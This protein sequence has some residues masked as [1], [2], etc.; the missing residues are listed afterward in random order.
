MENFIAWPIWIAIYLFLGG[1][2]AGA[3]LVAALSDLFG[4]EKYRSMARTAAWLVPGP[5]VLGLVLLIY[6]LGLPFAF[7]KLMIYPN[8]GSVM[9]IGV[10]L[11]GI[12]TP[13]AFIYAFMLTAQKGTPYRKPEG[14]QSFLAWAGIVLAIGVAAYTALLLQSVST[15]AIW[16]SSILPVL[17]LASAFSTGIALTIL[18]AHFSAP[19]AHEAI[20]TWTRYDAYL[21]GSELVIIALMVIGW[22][23]TAGGEVALQALV[24][25]GYAPLFW[26]GLILLGL[27]APL[28]LE[29]K[30]L[31]GK[32]GG[33]ALAIVASILI[34]MG[35]YLLRHV[36]LFAGQL[37]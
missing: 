31:Q 36:I 17:F 22:A 35:G 14:L 5:I 27:I 34:L 15:N 20:H 2:S 16:G 13:V 7:W 10:F 21:L 6:D 11:L 12:F 32:G 25:G 3:F 1:V 9:S 30:E 4:G 33:G 8:L 29:Y 24:F 23:V 37:A 18:V 19:D 26:V 28:I